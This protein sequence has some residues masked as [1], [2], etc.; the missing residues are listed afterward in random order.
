MTSTNPKLRTGDCQCSGIASRA[1]FRELNVYFIL[2]HIIFYLCYPTQLT[3]R[4]VVQYVPN[5]TH[6]ITNVFKHERYILITHLNIVLGRQRKKADF[7]SKK[8]QL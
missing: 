5:E 1:E 8:E 4:D 3:G 7:S 6:F 2:M